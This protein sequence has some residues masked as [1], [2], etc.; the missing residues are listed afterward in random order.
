MKRMLILSFALI[1]I[2]VSICFADY[3]YF[4]ANEQKDA[5]AVLNVYLNALIEGD[6]EGIRGSIGG[7]LLEKR[8]KLLDNPDYP[9]LL[10]DAYKDASFEI[11]NCKILKK[12]STQIDVRIDLNEKESRQLRFLLIKKAIFPDS[13][14]QFRIYSQTEMTK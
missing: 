2:F 14:A 1:M 9:S 6:M 12:D 5:V 13:S 3:Q 11:L 10:R 8:K 7:Y 4:T